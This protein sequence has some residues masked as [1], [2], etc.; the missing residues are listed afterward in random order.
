MIQLFQRRGFIYD[1]L[2]AILWALLIFVA[3][4]IPN[5][6]LPDL[7]FVPS[8]KAIHLVVYFIL[9][10]LVYRALLYQDRFPRLAKW[11]I[12]CTVLLS[13]VYGVSD[14]FHQSF[15]PNRDASMYDLAADSIG[16]FLFLGYSLL[17]RRS[18]SRAKQPD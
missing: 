6:T 8:D 5:I 4:S 3:S 14:E 16:A 9:C 12:A 2:P 15:V 17:R 7:D 18:N 1:Q 13:I 10:S 11:S